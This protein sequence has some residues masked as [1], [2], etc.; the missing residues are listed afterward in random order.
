MEHLFL[1][2]Q[3]HTFC[4]NHN[5]SICDNLK[6]NV[7]TLKLHKKWC[8]IKLKQKE[9]YNIAPDNNVLGIHECLI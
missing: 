1:T 5:N 8:S 6:K 4:I 2:E 7:T 9:N 3:V